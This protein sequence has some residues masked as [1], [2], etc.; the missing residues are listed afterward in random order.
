M[1]LKPSETNSHSP[2]NSPS[3]GRSRRTRKLIN[4]EIIDEDSSLSP[5]LLPIT[6]S[7]ILDH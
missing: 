4:D 5:T 6:M 3:V 2:A 7:S 1:S